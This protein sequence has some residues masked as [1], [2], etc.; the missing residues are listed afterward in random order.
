MRF[1]G[2]LPVF[3]LVAVNADARGPFHRRS[4]T[5]DQRGSGG[6][7]PS[8]DAQAVAPRPFI[9]GC[10]LE[11]E[12]RWSKIP[13]SHPPLRSEFDAACADKTK[14]VAYLAPS[15]LP[16]VGAI[17]RPAAVPGAA[18]TRAPAPIDSQRSN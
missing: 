8:S 11:V 6:S 15:Q 7:A 1:A 5:P 4:L 10:P 13:F 16:D 2:A 17:Q 9:E 3:L 12:A 14:K 18:I